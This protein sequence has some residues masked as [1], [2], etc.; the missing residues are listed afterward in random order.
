MKT[1]KVDALQPS[2]SFSK[3]V[4]RVIIYDEAEGEYLCFE[5]K[6]AELSIFFLEKRQLKNHSH[7]CLTI[8]CC[9]GVETYFG[10]LNYTDSN[11]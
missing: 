10:F 1:R 6:F 2:F 3:S 7:L 9:K 4:N 11:S 5:L 8:E